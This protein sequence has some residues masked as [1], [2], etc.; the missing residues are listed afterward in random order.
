ML[1]RI[2]NYDTIGLTKGTKMN[3]EILDAD[4]IPLIIGGIYRIKSSK[5]TNRF[6]CVRK[7][8]NNGTM[9]I[10]IHDN[11][12]HLGREFIEFKNGIGYYN[13]IKG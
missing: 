8:D 12:V 9:F 5:S 11:M 13:I 1:D 7:N 4:G 2:C 6:K 3:E 10:R